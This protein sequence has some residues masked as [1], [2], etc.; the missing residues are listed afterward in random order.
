MK[1]I[2]NSP[3]LM[4]KACSVLHR[5]NQLRSVDSLGKN[6]KL[7]QAWAD[8]KSRCYNPKSSEYTRYGSR[9]ITVCNAWLNSSKTFIEW[10]IT[11]GDTSG[12][13][14][15]RIDN[16]GNYEPDNCRWATKS[17]QARNTRVL[18]SNNTS[19]YK[20]VTLDKRRGT[21]Q[22]KIQVNGKHVHIGIYTKAFEA[23]KAYD[24]YVKSNNLEHSI[25]FK[26]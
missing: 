4:C 13:S 1:Q 12:L 24:T 21:Y 19:G 10:A 2:K 3:T 25:N 15:D 16:N 26:E 17:T 22:A 8:M 14:L 23:A 20:G 5:G 6:K 18:G 7:Y 11:F 9:G